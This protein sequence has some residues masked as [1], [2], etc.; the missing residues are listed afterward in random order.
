M[1]ELHTHTF[2]S[3]GDLGPA[4]LLRR[5][6][7]TGARGVALTDHADF[8]CVDRLVPGLVAACE[9][10][11]RGGTLLAVPGAEVTHVRPGEIAACV[12]RARELGARL[13][14]VHGE[15]L[16]E[17]VEPGTNRAGIEAGADVLAHP[18]M[19]EVEDARLAAE[20]GVRLEISSR[21][22]HCLANGHVARVAREA[23][24]KHVFGS[25]AHAPEDRNTRE[26]ALRVL[27]GAGLDEAEAAEALA[28]S[29]RLLE[30]KGGGT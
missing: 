22:G 15:T 21:K 10:E 4:E 25:D 11:A 29:A 7:A 23:G 8:A 19:L 9:S 1:I 17:P 20:R 12:A 2:L 5:A 16:S 14:L 13:V 6:E 3:D 24:A 18:G 30:A 27:R 28:E 26:S